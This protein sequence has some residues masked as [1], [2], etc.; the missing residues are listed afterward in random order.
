MEPPREPRDSQR[1]TP[2]NFIHEP[3]SRTADILLRRRG[4]QDGSRLH[5]GKLHRSKYT[6]HVPINIHIHTIICLG[7]TCHNTVHTI[8]IEPL[9]ASEYPL[10]QVRY[11]LRLVFICCASQHINNL[12]R[13]REFLANLSIPQLRLCTTWLCRPD[14]CNN[15]II[16]LHSIR[17]AFMCGIAMLLL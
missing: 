7:L 2:I 8:C 9:P 3:A 4:P 6:L 16:I 12:S 1:A 17:T 11:H 14:G 13:T 10:S 15:S 5:K